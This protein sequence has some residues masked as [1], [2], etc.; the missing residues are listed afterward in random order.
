[1]KSKLLLNVYYGAVVVIF[2]SQ[3]RQSFHND[4]SRPI[5]SVSGTDANQAMQEVAILPNYFLLLI[6]L[7]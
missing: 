5:M 2:S 3:F 4:S 6:F 1:M 7:A